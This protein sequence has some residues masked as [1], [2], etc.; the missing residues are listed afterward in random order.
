MILVNLNFKVDH[1]FRKKFKLTAIDN[2][3]SMRAFLKE[4]FQNWENTAMLTAVSRKNSD[5]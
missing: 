4:I 2:G 3:M 1:S 5:D